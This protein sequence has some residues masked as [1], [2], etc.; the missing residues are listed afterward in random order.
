M[1]VSTHV[2]DTERGRPAAGVRVELH[3]ADGDLVG[4]GVT[5]ADGRITELGDSSAGT[6]RIVFH[7]PSPF[8]KR[9]ELEVELGEGHHHVPLLISSYACASYRGS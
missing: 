1:T 3:D 5:D 8:F 4:E 7:P 9:V 6:Y 2:L